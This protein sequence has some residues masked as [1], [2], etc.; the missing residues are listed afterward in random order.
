[1]IKE[2]YLALKSP[3]ERED[4]I[5]KHAV[6]M[7]VYTEGLLIRNRYSAEKVIWLVVVDFQPQLIFHRPNDEHVICRVSRMDL[8]EGFSGVRWSSIQKSFKEYLFKECT[9]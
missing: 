2:E 5:H 3:H 6:S 4:F 8:K 1:M 9:K 7:V